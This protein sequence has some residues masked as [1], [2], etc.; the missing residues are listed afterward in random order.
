MTNN[1]GYFNDSWILIIIPILMLGSVTLMIYGVV[2]KANIDSR[3]FNEKYN[4]NYTPTDFLWDGDTIRDYLLYGTQKTINI[5]GLQ[6]D[7]N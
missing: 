4:T 5:R 1:K 6:N 3:L 2:T 7:K